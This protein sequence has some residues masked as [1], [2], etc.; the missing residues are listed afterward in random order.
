MSFLLVPNAAHS[1]A[2]KP[3]SFT[4]WMSAPPPTHRAPA[5]PQPCNR[6]RG[7][8]RLRAT[9]NARRRLIDR[10]RRRRRPPTRASA[11]CRRLL[12]SP[13]KLHHVSSAPMT[14]DS[15]AEHVI[16]EPPVGGL[17]PCDGSPAASASRH[18]TL[19]DAECPPF[20]RRAI[21]VVEITTAIAKLIG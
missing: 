19:R 4:A 20:E 5:S 12:R 18:Q 7:H 10:R 13:T 3:C 6:G 9:R 8:L 1:I 11:R 2:V 14:N 15:L 16:P 17:H 21:K